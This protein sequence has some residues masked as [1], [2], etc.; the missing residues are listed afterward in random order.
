MLAHPRSSVHHAVCAPQ[1]RT[2]LTR[3]RR[4][5]SVA[6]L[7]S[8]LRPST[9]GTAGSEAAADVAEVSRLHERCSRGVPRAYLQLARAQLVADLAR[10]C[11]AA[12]T[13]NDACAETDVA[14]TASGAD[15]PPMASSVLLVHGAE[16]RTAAHAVA[17]LLCS[18]GPAR[19]PLAA[20]FEDGRAY[21]LRMVTRYYSATLSL[22]VLPGARRS[23]RAAPHPLTARCAPSLGRHGRDARAPRGVEHVGGRAHLALRLV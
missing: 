11:A 13:E 21:E 6:L 15:L 8:M 14:S 7:A 18:D 12:E 3:A 5:S 16:M 1:V 9:L 17:G 2:L 19:G 22:V 20:P 4:A 23:T 10:D